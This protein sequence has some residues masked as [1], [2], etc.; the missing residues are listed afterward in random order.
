MPHMQHLFLAGAWSEISLHPDN[1]DT[2]NIGECIRKY[3]PLESC[4]YLPPVTIFLTELFMSGSAS[5]MFV[6]RDTGNGLKYTEKA[7]LSK[8]QYW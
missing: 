4:Q 7:P 8:F 3:I 6:G 1:H 2:A 5:A